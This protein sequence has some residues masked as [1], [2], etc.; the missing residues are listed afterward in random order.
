MFPYRSHRIILALVLGVAL[1]GPLPWAAAQSSATKVPRREPRIAAMQPDILAR[2]WERLG[3]VF[4]KTGCSIDPHGRFCQIGAT[5]GPG[6][7]DTGC[8]LDP[9]G[10]CATGH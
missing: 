7:A 4:L 3:W 1:I 8:S 6:Q 2:L 5:T 10:G 9:H